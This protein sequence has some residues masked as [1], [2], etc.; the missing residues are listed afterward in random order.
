MTPGEHDPHAKPSKDLAGAVR[1]AEALHRGIGAASARIIA[2]E[3][4][5]GDDGALATFAATG[6]LHPARALH[7]LAQGQ[8]GGVL[9]ARRAAALIGFIEEASPFR[10]TKPDTVDQALELSWPT[11]STSRPRA[12]SAAG[13]SSTATG[14]R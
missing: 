10:S 2:A 1:L 9:T 12:A 5:P 6:S 13:S 14:T 11:P 8:Y 7:E 4:S 3:L